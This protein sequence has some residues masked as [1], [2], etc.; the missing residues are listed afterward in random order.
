M[1]NLRHLE[2]SLR[3]REFAMQS[4]NPPVAKTGTIPELMESAPYGKNAFLREPDGV[5]RIVNV[6]QQLE[7]VLG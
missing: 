3:E 2:K 1:R 5:V 7:V 6:N 4:E